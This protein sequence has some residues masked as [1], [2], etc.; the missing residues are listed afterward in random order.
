[1]IIGKIP[2][3]LFSNESYLCYIPYISYT[4]LHSQ[5]SESSQITCNEPYLIL[6]LPFFVF[7]ISISF[8]SKCLLSTITFWQAKGTSSLPNLYFWCLLPSFFKELLHWQFRLLLSTMAKIFKYI[9][10]IFGKFIYLV[11]VFDLPLE[12]CNSFVLMLICG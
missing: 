4:N 9:S 7:L 11:S 10:Q 12:L 2:F 3:V 5:G 8:L 1:M 6:L